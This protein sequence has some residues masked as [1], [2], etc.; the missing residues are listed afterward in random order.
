MD[1]LNYVQYEDDKEGE[2]DLV[3]YAE[4]RPN[5]VWNVVT[6][7]YSTKDYVRMVHD[8]YVELGR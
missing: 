7:N 5:L 1:I 3:G 6:N 4:D 2:N 8:H